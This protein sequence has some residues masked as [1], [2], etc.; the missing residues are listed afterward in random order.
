MTP[1]QIKEQ[2]KAAYDIDPEQIFFDEKGS[3]FF[4]HEALQLLAIKLAPQV[5]N[6]EIELAQLSKADR[7]VVA[8]CSV[9]LEDGRARTTTGSVLLSTAGS[10]EDENKAFESAVLLANSRALRSGL[11]S[12]GFDPIKAHLAAQNGNV[13]ELKPRTAADE[14]TITQKAIHALRDEMN[15][16]D[17]VYRRYLI[18]AT[19]KSSTKQMNEQEIRQALT[20]LQALNEGRKMRIAA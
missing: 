1:E 15:L 6:I 5:R 18:L 16:A 3:P 14:F 7:F 12:I 11:R 13:I 17:D 9:Y 8:S 2:F 19:K 20:Y 4:D 10:E